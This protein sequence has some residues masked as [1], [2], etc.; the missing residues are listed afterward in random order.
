MLVYQ[1]YTYMNYWGMPEFLSDIFYYAIDW[2]FSRSFGYEP[3]DTKLFVNA[4]DGVAIY[5]NDD[6]SP[7]IVVAKTK[8]NKDDGSIKFIFD[9]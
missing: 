1:P 9:I 5:C 7:N 6:L 8:K 2:Q 3:D 4:K